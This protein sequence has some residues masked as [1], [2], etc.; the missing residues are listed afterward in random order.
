[1]EAMDTSLSVN[2]WI[3]VLDDSTDRAREALARVLVTALAGELAT[4]VRALIEE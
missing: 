2:V 3:D 4:E 1:M